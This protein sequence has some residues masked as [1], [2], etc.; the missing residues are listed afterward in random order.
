MSSDAGGGCVRFVCG[1]VPTA[2]RERGQWA[3]GSGWWTKAVGG[4]RA[5]ERA[6]DEALDAAAPPAL[7][8]G[9][10]FLNHGHTHTAPASLAPQQADGALDGCDSLPVALPA[11]TAAVASCL[12]LTQEERANTPKLGA[13]RTG[14]ARLLWAA[15]KGASENLHFPPST[16]H[17]R[18]RLHSLALSL[19]IPPPPLPPARPLEPRRLDFSSTPSTLTPR[20]SQCTLERLRGRLG[21]RCHS[22]DSRQPL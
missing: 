22:V 5:S 12:T 6:R 13:A 19:S 17:H 14:P 15:L 11:C 4:E 20:C 8:P 18:R 1:R 2:G 3:M 7:H 16:S 10:H 9:Q 21:T